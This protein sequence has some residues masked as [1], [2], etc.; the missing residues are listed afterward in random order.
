M[1]DQRTHYVTTSDGVTIGATLHGQGPPL[2]FLQGVIG[3]G[4][5][6]WGPVAEHL[7]DRFTCHLPSMRGRGLSGDHP[8]LSVDRLVDDVITYVDSIGSSP[9]LVGW[10]L[11]AGLSLLVAARCDAISAVAP[12]DPLA[13]SQMDE[14]ERAAL[15][16]AVA[17]AGALAAEGDLAAAIRA[18]AEYPFN[19]KDIAVAEETGYFEASARYVPDLLAFFGQMMEG[20]GG[21][22]SDDPSVLGAI[23]VPML[24]LYGSDTTPFGE[25]SARH[26]S[27]HVASARL[28]E[29]P[30]AGHTAPL[31]H[32]EELAETLAEFFASADQPA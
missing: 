15:G 24:V 22:P 4:D 29:I 28:H 30:G 3:D 13:V 8:D 2:V 25:F 14:E 11:G 10:S 6:D 7:S 16:G 32:P 18:F 31:T 23:S 20:D 26:V 5:L 1:S 21:P 17:R 19:E 9:G 12:L 27:E